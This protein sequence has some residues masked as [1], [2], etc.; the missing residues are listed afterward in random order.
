MQTEVAAHW[1][2]TARQ[3]CCCKPGPLEGDLANWQ[4]YHS[5]ASQ[6]ASTHLSC[7]LQLAH[8]L[9]SSPLHPQQHVSPSASRNP[10]FTNSPNA[11]LQVLGVRRSATKAEITKAFRQLSK[12]WH[13]DKNSSPEATEKFQQISA[14]VVCMFRGSR[15]RPLSWKASLSFAS[16]VCAALSCNWLGPGSVLKQQRPEPCA[17]LLTCACSI[18]A[19]E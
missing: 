7:T 3:L 5:A 11:F 16:A 18:R 13:P 9:T 6:V 19:F 2:S 14:G 4:L 1:S 8:Q 10:C 15:L 12:Q 17:T